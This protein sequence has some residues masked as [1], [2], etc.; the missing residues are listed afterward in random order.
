MVMMTCF[1]MMMTRFAISSVDDATI[2]PTPETRSFLTPSWAGENRAGG[3]FRK[4][5]V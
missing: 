5:K 1:M 4:L 2:G 3:S